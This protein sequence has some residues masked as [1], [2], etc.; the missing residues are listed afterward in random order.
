M[1]LAIVSIKRIEVIHDYIED[2][3]LGWVLGDSQVHV[4]FS[5]SHVAD[6]FGNEE[7]V[8]IEG[9]VSQEVTQLLCVG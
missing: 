8:N 1:T 2:V 6:A 4:V 7:V 9:Y 5:L 3:A